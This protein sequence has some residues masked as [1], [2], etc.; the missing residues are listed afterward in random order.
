MPQRTSPREELDL[1]T[2]VDRYF[3][4][5]LGDADP[6]LEAAL[7]S[8]E[9]AGLPSI[10]VSPLQ[11]KLLHLLARAAGARRILEVG[12]L[13]GYSALWLARALPPGGKLVTLELEA[14][15]AE[16]ARENLARG[17]VGDRVE[18]RLG[19]AIASLDR[20]AEERAPPFD[21]VFVDADKREYP[22]YLERTIPLCRPGALWIAD[23]VVRR[24]DVADGASVDPY[25]QGVRR[26]TEALG[27]DGRL[28]AT[29]VQTVGT[30][31]YDGLALA[32]V[33]DPAGPRGGRP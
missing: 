5:A 14:K 17:G 25:V 12:T 18:I 30:K 23:N 22:E 29:V 6:A 16:V 24:G 19:P 20:L 13:G 21:L 4:A 31:G 32:L 15:H 1:W 26:M 3:G 8:S 27:R 28:S 10:Q 11:G 33:V 2:A 9:A 7:R